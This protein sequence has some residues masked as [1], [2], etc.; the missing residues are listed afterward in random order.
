MFM[1]VVHAFPNQSYLCPAHIVLLHIRNACMITMKQFILWQ[2]SNQF[3]DNHI[4]HINHS[5]TVDTIDTVI[6]FILYQNN[7]EDSSCREVTSKKL[8]Y[9]PD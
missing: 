5:A 1:S 3:V 8:A 4:H 9:D 2:F 6:C 7:Q